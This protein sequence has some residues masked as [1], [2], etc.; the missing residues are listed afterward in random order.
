MYRELLK[1]AHGFQPTQSWT[2]LSDKGREESLRGR[3]LSGR[4][5]HVGVK[6]I[7]HDQGGEV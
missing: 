1:I 5:S 7:K 3:S 2:L 4:E 6:G